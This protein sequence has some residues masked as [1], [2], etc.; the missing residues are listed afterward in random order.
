MNKGLHAGAV[1]LACLG[2]LLVYA[3]W[4]GL[5]GEQGAIRAP[6]EFIQHCGD[7]TC[8]EAHP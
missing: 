2:V 7:M 5:R 1:G 4:L 3:G 6:G 8:R